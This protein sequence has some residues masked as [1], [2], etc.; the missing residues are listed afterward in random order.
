MGSWAVTRLERRFRDR[1]KR[2]RAVGTGRTEGP[3]AS[4]VMGG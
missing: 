3:G 1:M 4:N 2:W